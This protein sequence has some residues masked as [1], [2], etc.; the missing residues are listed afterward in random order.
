M[1]GPLSTMIAAATGALLSPVGTGGLPEKLCAPH[2]NVTP[3]K[4]SAMMLQVSKT[5]LER[6]PANAANAT[7]VARA[8][9]TATAETLKILL[10]N[11]L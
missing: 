2:T 6:L 7:T 5:V 4:A 11:E 10:I 1:V 9:Q 3:H 8:A